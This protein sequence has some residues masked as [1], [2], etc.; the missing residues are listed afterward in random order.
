[1]RAGA[2]EALRADTV[3]EAEVQVFVGD[4]AG[5]GTRPR[6][7]ERIDTTLPLCT[8]PIQFR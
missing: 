3:G 2:Q 4:V 5:E 1:M 6:N 8:S 7:R